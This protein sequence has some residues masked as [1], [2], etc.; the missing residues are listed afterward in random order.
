MDTTHIACTAEDLISYRLQ[1]AELLVTKPK[2][3]REGADLIVFM[4]VRDG[5]KFCKVQCKGRSLAKSKSSTNIQ[6][7]KS[8]VTDAFVLLLYI[9]DGFEDKLNLFCFFSDDI[10]E[11]WKLKK[12]KESSKDIY[13]LNISESVFKNANKKGNLIEYIFNN[14]KIEQ[15]KNIIKNSDSKKEIEPLIDLI[16][17][18]KRLIKLQKIAHRL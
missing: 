12:F 3:D 14:S 6:V 18:Q 15:L 7:F 13:R 1:Q 11:K 10:K 9:D 5:A 17:K 8:Y 2:F 16:N 4:T